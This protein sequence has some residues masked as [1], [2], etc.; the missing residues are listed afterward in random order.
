MGRR[1]ELTEAGRIAL[2][3]A[4]RIFAVE[5]D[6][7]AALKGTGGSPR[8][9]RV[10][11]AATLSRNLQLRVLEPALRAGA[12]LVLRSGGTAA[13]VA[14]LRALNLDLVLSAEPPGALE[15]DLM[16][17]S[18][19]DEAVGLH[20]RPALLKA[21][22][23]PL[24]LAQAAFV[25]PS[26]PGIRAGFAALADRHGVRPRVAADVDDMAMVRL[27]AREGA[28]V[29][30]APAVVLRDELADGTL[31]TAPYP[32]GIVQRFHALTA[33]RSFPHPLLATLLPAAA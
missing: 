22:D 15:G 32:T 13:L 25:L 16:A 1:L 21:P 14:D 20:A 10:G 12:E 7:L 8:P 18:L 30:V 33:R 26:D 28:G 29:A 5:G 2:D 19:A 17:H 24:L 23:L 3:H 27:L 9:L 31:A 6:L 4:D 11:A